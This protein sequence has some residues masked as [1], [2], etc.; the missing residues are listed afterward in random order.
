MLAEARV[1]TAVILY[2]VQLHLQG[3]VAALVIQELL[4]LR[5]VLAVLVAVVHLEL[6][7]QV[8]REHLVKDTLVVVVTT[9]VVDAVLVVG[10]ALVQLAQIQEQMTLG[11]EV[12]AAQE[13]AQLLQANAF[14]MQGAV[15]VV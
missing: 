10:E 2:L 14:F 1:L 5:P 6:L 8:D 12:Q 7:L 9:L 3:A 11:L 4:E 15:V 13:C